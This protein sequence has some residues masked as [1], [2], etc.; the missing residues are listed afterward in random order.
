[1]KCVGTSK[2]ASYNKMEKKKRSEEAR[3]KKEDE[4]AM[5]IFGTVINR[6]PVIEDPKSKYLLVFPREGGRW[7]TFSGTLQ[8]V[9]D[10]D[11]G[12]KMFSEF[13]ND[14]LYDSKSVEDDIS[15]DIENAKHTI[16]IKLKRSSKPTPDYIVTQI[17]EPSSNKHTRIWRD[18]SIFTFDIQTPI[19]WEEIDV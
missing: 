4:Y 7:A 2:A 1:M 19:N 11:S 9:R 18:I 13:V 5:R 16:M 12:Y 14:R 15:Q 8:R 10:F 6:E 17:E 3:I